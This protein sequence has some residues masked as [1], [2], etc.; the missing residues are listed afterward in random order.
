M[1]KSPP[2]F[3]TI[4]LSA[5]IEAEEAKPAQQQKAQKTTE[6]LH[7]EALQF[8]QRHRSDGDDTKDCSFMSP[9]RSLTPKCSTLNLTPKRTPRMSPGRLT[10]GMKSPSVC[11]SPFVICESGGTIFG[12]TLRKADNCSLGLDVEHTDGGN[13]LEV[14]GVKPGGAMN[15]WNKLC[16]GGPSAGKAVGP[17]DRIVKVNNATTPKEMLQE[18]RDQ[19]LLKFM[20]QR[21]EVED[22]FELT[23]T[24]LQDDMSKRLVC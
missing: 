16:V 24:G 2:A 12:F 5:A 11:A 14:T 8:M 21:G 4:S 19:T 23:M 18:C 13:F 22:D 3:A 9:A 1:M 15:A 17:G 10:P 20:V 6:E 7:K